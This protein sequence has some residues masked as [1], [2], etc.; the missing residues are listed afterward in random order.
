[1]RSSFA[2]A[3]SSFGEKKRRPSWKLI[4][5]TGS[6]LT[7]SREL[8]IQLILRASFH[9]FSL[10]QDAAERGAQNIDDGDYL[11][12]FTARCTGY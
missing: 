12:N 2:F 9:F 6:S 4:F 8:F 1:M 7:L 3:S 10:F 11:I 5:I